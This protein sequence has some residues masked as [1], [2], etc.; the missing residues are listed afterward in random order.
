MPTSCG[1]ADIC[2][3][4]LHANHHQYL[5]V[6]NRPNAAALGPS[7]CR[8]TWDV[9][10]FGIPIGPFKLS[11]ALRLISWRSTHRRP[12]NFD[13]DAR[14]LLSTIRWTL[15]SLHGGL[16]G[17]TYC[18]LLVPDE[19]ERS[20]AAQHWFC[21]HGQS[22]QHWRHRC[23]FHI[24]AQ[25]FAL[26]PHWVLR[27][28]WRG[29]AGHGCEYL[30]RVIGAQGEAQG[31]PGCRHNCQCACAFF[32]SQRVFFWFFFCGTSIWYNSVWSESKQCW[33]VVEIEARILQIRT[34][35]AT[36]I[37]STKYSTL[38]GLTPARQTCEGG[39]P[40]VRGIGDT[41]QARCIVPSFVQY[42]ARAP[43]IRSKYIYMHLPA[44][45]YYTI[46]GNASSNWHGRE[47][48]RLAVK[49]TGKGAI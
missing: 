8:R 9:S 41:F 28:Y 4:L 42:S 35:P 29:G 44:C 20:P 10:A 30:L 46:G 43:G 11:P 6:L 32:M 17:G 37:L 38:G 2:V 23:T 19:L 45:K 27:V 24:C 21:I 31:A 15:P 34:E 49:F 7:I 16:W 33:R 26:L 36:C 1:R 3:R 12:C 47:G 14:A 25:G 22:G 5:G 18:H 13:D 40:R 39:P 48:I